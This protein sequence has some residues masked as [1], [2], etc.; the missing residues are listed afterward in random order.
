L[1]EMY[2]GV[3]V[4]GKRGEL[5]VC[6]DLVLRAF[7]VAQHGLRGFLIVPEIGLSDA[8]FERVQAFAMR[9][10]VKDSSVPS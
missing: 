6:G 8:G 9:S 1:R 5:F 2:V 3:E 10:S 4:A 7:A